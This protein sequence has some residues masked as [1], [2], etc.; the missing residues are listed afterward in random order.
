MRDNIRGL[1]QDKHYIFENVMI[2]GMVKFLHK[3]D[4]V[5][6]NSITKYLEKDFEKA[7]KK[8]CEAYDKEF[9]P[10]YNVEKTETQDTQQNNIG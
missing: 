7:R 9:K 1:R 5:K 4:N 6:I 2:T 8:W 10:I 3:I